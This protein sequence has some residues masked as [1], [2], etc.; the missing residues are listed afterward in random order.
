MASP[1]TW[2]RSVLRLRP[3]FD[4]AGEPGIFAVPEPREKFGIFR[5]A[6]PRTLPTDYIQRRKI[7]ILPSPRAYIEGERSEFFQVL[8][9]RRKFGIFLCPRNMKK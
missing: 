4:G 2:L 8:E 3:V 1:R 6:T 9:P 5:R 7:E